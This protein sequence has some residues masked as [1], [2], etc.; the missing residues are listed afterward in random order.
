ML[1]CFS[2]LAADTLDDAEED[3]DEDSDEDDGLTFFA[4][5]DSS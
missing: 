2:L 3:S 1:D 4:V 5:F